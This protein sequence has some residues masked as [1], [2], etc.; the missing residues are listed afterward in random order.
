MTM[1]S[2]TA[3]QFLT[4]R[5]FRLSRGEE[6]AFVAAVYYL[7]PRGD[8]DVPSCLSNDRPPQIYVH[9]CYME[10]LEWI[11]D[12]RRFVIGI[13]NEAPQGRAHI[14]FYS[15]TE[16]ELV[17]KY[18]QLEAALLAAWRALFDVLGE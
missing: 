9:D 10:Q 1:R 5:G 3:E 15:L 11:T 8:M 12:Y 18:E 14:T 7:A 2:K 6:N 16:E 17:E 4:A 13:R